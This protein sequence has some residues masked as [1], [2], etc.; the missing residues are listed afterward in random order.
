L[1]ARQIVVDYASIPRS[2]AEGCA[3]LDP[4][5]PPGD[6]PLKRWQQFVDDV[7]IFLDCG[8]HRDGGRHARI[9]GGRR[10]TQL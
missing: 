6:I 5:R 1:I 10:R 8:Q 7:S 2:W 9:T 3:R 4:D